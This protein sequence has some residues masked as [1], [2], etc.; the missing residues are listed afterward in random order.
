VEKPPVNEEN[1]KSEESRSCN[2]REFMKTTGS[3][4]VAAALAHFVFLG[5]SKTANAQ[6]LPPGCTYASDACGGTGAD[7]A[8]PGDACNGTT[9]DWC[10]SGLPAND[11][12]DPNYPGT[13][14]DDNCPVVS[15][16]SRDTCSTKKASYGEGDL[17]SRPSGI[18]AGV[19]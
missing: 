10:D 1:P 12:C 3:I 5:G 18:D 6:T 13:S 19:A 4:S 15:S 9:T 11:V 14:L 16:I 17:C 8:S 2:R 7:C